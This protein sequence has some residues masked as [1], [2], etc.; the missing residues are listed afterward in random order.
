MATDKWLDWIVNR[1][2]GGDKKQAEESMKQMN[3]LRDKIIGDAS[4]KDGDIVLDIGTGD[5]LL[6]F[7]AL[8]KVGPN[9]KVIFSDISE[10]CVE[11]CKEIYSS[12]ESPNPAEFIVTPAQRL[13]MDD[14]SVDVVMFR[15]VLIYIK[16]KQDCFKEFY[17]VLKPG[18]RISFFEPINIFTKRHQSKH[19][20]YGHDV[21]PI[22]D[23]WEKIR[24]VFPGKE[25]PDHPMLNFDEDDLFRFVRDAGFGELS[26]EVNARS[27]KM[28]VGGNW[29]F[30]FKSAPN[31]N[32]L[33]LEEA[34]NKT[35]SSKENTKFVE[36][37]KQ[38]IENDPSIYL[39]AIC[40]LNAVK[41]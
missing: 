16:E 33:T 25:E 21:S 17:R 36:F 5:G 18:G 26:M 19:T 22:K 15:S 10:S 28:P 31:P 11:A 38:K 13:P 14:N 24:T 39:M 23:I 7:G 4:I 8:E 37:M 29:H 1:R 27:Q 6:G 20:F 32:S 9:G 34:A 41:E 40:Y 2:Y 35:L 30:L 12:M 3:M